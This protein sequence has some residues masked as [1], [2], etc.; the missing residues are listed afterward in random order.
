MRVVLKVSVKY[1]GAYYAPG[2]SLEMKDDV[3]AEL[4]SAGKAIAAETPKS[5]ELETDPGANVDDET[6][7]GDEK[8]NG[9]KKGKKK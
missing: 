4:L 3:A 9:K 1:G 7:D 8:P 6:P 2:T 5:P